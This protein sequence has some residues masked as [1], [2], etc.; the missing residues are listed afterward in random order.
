[1]R[2]IAVVIVLA[3]CAGP[4]PTVAP[5]SAAPCVPPTAGTAPSYSEL[6][7]KYFA[8]NTPGHCATAH[9]HADPGHDT[10][11]CGTDAST[12]YPGMVQVG[13]INVK[14]PT[15]SLIGD[16]SQS[17]LSWISPTG[18]MPF[19]ITGPFPDGRDAILAWVAACAQND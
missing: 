6:Y 16:A 17:P 12:C 2:C 11:L 10:W 9:C 13:L 5:D 7:A 3:S 4:A 8:P 18:D 14:N 19:D 1:M 15:A